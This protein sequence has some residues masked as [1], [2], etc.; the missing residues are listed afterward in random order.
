MIQDF[1]K[2]FWLQ[3][4]FTYDPL[5]GQL[6]GI[7]HIIML[8]IS[9]LFFVIFWHFGKKAKNKD[10]WMI[11]TGSLLFILELLR[12]L[13]FHYV[14]NMSW[15]GALSFH[16]CS[17][18]VYL[19]IIAGLFRRKWMFEM[20][21]LHALLA[22]PMAI[23]IPTGILPWH[24]P[25]S[26]LPLQ[27][28][29]SHVLLWFGIV[30]A[31]KN[32]FFKVSYKRYY[33]PVASVLL[34]T[35]LAYGMSMYNLNNNTGGFTNFFWT[36]YGEPMFDI[37]V[38]LPYPYYLIVLLTLLIGAGFFTYYLFQRWEQKRNLQEN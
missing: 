27:S 17:I 9:V 38:P 16:L 18:G 22:S 33:I 24:N 3:E 7:Y 37:I 10:A 29:I 5:E 1:I 4:G 25:Y 14:Y 31:W 32:D 20:V 11:F 8:V 23:L 28:Y 12:V 30:Y 15:V 21:F 2:Y 35:V 19:M 6:L 26:F 34:S 13:N 36:R